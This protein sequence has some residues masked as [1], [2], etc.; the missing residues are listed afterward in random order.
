M[1]KLN[2]LWCVLAAILWSVDSQAQNAITFWKYGRATII[3]SPDSITFKDASNSQNTG[4]ATTY[5][6]DGKATVVYSPD[7]MFLWNNSSFF[8]GEQDLEGTA[9]PTEM[10][11]FLRQLSSDEEKVRVT[12]YSVADSMKYDALAQ[13]V[14]STNSINR[15]RGFVIEQQDRN[16]GLW[17]KTR[18]GGFN[19]YYNTFIENDKRF[20]LVV[21][22]YQ[23]GFPNKKT[24]YVKLG[25]VNSGPIVGAVTI[26][27]GQECAFVKVCLDDYIQGYGCANFFP[28]LITEGSKARNYLNPIFVKSDPIVSANWREQTFGSAFGTV[29]GVSVYYNKDTYDQKRGLMR[30][31]STVSD[32]FYQSVELCER[33]VKNLNGHIKRTSGWGN[34]IKWPTNRANDDVDPGAYIVFPNDGKNQVREGDLIVWDRSTWGHIG[35]VVKTTENDITIAH[36]NGGVGTNALPIGTTLKLENGI[37][38]DVRPGSDHSPIFAGVTPIPSF[39]RINSDAEGSATYATT[40]TI[41]TTNLRFGE[42]EVGESSSASFQISNPSGNS[43]LTVSSVRLSSGEAF[44]TDASACTIE[45]GETKTF[46]VTFAPLSGGDYEDRIVITSNAQDNPTWTIK[47]S[48]TG[49]GLV[50]A[51]TI[52]INPRRINFGTVMENVPATKYFTVTNTGDYDLTF[53][54]SQPVYPFTIPEAGKNITLRQGGSH[55]V[56]VTCAGLDPGEIVENVFVRISSN[57]TNKEEVNGITLSAN[58][59]GVGPACPALVTMVELAGVEYKILEDLPNIMYFNVSALLNDQTD[60]EE[61]GLY[62]NKDQEKL[63]FS[64]KAV[65]RGETM[66]LSCSSTGENGLM[67]LDINNFVATYDDMVGVYV[68]KRD[69]TTGDLLTIYGD[70]FRFSLRYD[71]PPSFT[72]SSPFILDTQVLEKDGDNIKYKTSFMFHYDL[73]GAFWIDYIDTGIS[74]QNWTLGENAIWVAQKDRYGDQT[75]SENY[76]SNT[77]DLGHSIWRILHLRNYTTLKSNCLNFKGEG[78]LTDVWVTSMPVYVPRSLQ[79]KQV[80]LADAQNVEFPYVLNM[81]APEEMNAKATPSKPFKKSFPYKGGVLGAY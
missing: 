18:Y 2:I 64:F 9:T 32:A 31:Q 1:K 13:D 53:N 62:F 58:G 25:Q 66:T 42:V 52:N 28:L 49:E 81:T 40:M 15:F 7:S 27:P 46:S 45:P 12:T 65:Q 68:K 30:N 4:N 50:L 19:A 73:R 56:E 24:A 14:I 37:V 61:W 6:R 16:T 8:V 36:Q 63:E 10:E 39:I 35:V 38:K 51:G 76:W 77:G 72:F 43:T 26:Y 21:F 57:A 17:G 80:R 34:A 44:S 60:V 3:D 23:G 22:Y 20:I 54:I 75:W 59:A 67:K 70:M 29:N 48:G 69:R 47:L 41:N 11:T 74:G 5:W 71:T 55:T 33:Y 78:K 79:G